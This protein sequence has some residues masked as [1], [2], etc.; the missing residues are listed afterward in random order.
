M[1]E[2]KS[3]IQALFTFIGVANSGKHYCCELLEKLNP[4]IDKLKTFYMDQYSGGVGA[5][6]ELVIIFHKEII[7]FVTKNPNRIVVFEDIE[8][9]DLQIQLSLYTLLTDY[10]KSDLDFSKI[11]VVITTTSLS[12][13]LQR[14]DLQNL[15]KNDHLQ[16]HTF[17]MEHLAKEQI[18]VG[19]GIDIDFDKKIL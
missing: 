4:K 16:A 6:Q 14:K 12:S 5:Q 3:K 13:L 7:D 9:A 2:T 11:V 15:I 17:L 8:K 10:E 19:D 1:L 18:S